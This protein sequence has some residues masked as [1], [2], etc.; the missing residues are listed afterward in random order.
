MW[1]RK[2]FQILDILFAPNL[3]TFFEKDQSHLYIYNDLALGKPHRESSF[4]IW[5]E[6]IGQVKEKKYNFRLLVVL[7]RCNLKKT[8]D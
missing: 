5:T 1:G 6:M 7:I 4:I 2:Y 8:R 3:S